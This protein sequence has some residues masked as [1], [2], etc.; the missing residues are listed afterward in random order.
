MEALPKVFDSKKEKRKKE[1]E[2]GIDDVY[3][4]VGQLEVENDFLK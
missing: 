1:Q 2:I 4:R 3:K